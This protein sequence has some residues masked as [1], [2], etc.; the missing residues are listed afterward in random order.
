MT[1]KETNET[2]NALSKKEDNMI[3]RSSTDYDQLMRAFK[4]I[5]A[6]NSK[7][8]KQLSKVVDPKLLNN[9]LRSSLNYTDQK[10]Y[11]ELSCATNTAYRFSHEIDL[12]GKATI[13]KQKF[14]DL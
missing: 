8:K 5:E 10:E 2:I 7:M 3:M 9:F 14:N 12:L 6:Q 1:D 11:S 4:Q 13:Y